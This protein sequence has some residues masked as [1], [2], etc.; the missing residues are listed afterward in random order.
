MGPQYAW[1]AA[2]LIVL[3]I[4]QF[5]SMSQYVSALVLAGMARH[6]ILAYVALGEGVANLLLSIVLV[7]R[8]GVIGV[9]WGT[10]IPHL[11]STTLVIPF[12]TLRILR[13]SVREYV[14]R[15]FVR[16]ILC[17]LPIAV[18]CYGFSQYVATPTW[19]TFAGEVAA[20]AVVLGITGYCICLTAAQQASIMGKLHGFMRREAA[21]VDGA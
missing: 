7:K 6:K 15:G 4:P 16:P 14:G 18:L 20:V 8:I 13:M 19:M 5:T 1:S 3:T 10:V 21:I 2:I 12:Y 17:S 9:A 11:I